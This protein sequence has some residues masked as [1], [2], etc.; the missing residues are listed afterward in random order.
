MKTLEELRSLYET[1]LLP[2]LGEYEA[3]RKKIC[4]ALSGVG[5]GA[6]ALVL[7]GFLA[8]PARGGSPLLLIVAIILAVGA[9]ILTYVL[10]ARGF[11]D[12]FKHDV[13]GRIVKFC[14]PTLVYSPKR[15]ITEPQFKQSR[16][17]ERRID[18]YK[19]EDH[20]AGTIG[21]T[22]IEF[23]EVHAEYKTTTRSSKGHTQTHW[24][25]IF[26]GLFFIGDFNKDFRTLTVVLPDVAERLFGF[27][28][29]KLQSMNILRTGKPVRLEDPEFEK[30]F[31]VYGQDQIEARYVLSTSLMRRILDFKRKTGSQIYLSFVGSH[32]HLG[33]STN[34]NMFEPRLFRTLIDFDLVQSY[35]E[36]LQLAV[37]IVEDLNLNTRIWTKE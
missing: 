3:R 22:H 8:G 1:D 12:G 28:G 36:D 31:A 10:M 37:G 25:T 19:G 6:A 14:D 20:V 33:I 29:A 21:K 9:L 35:L 18:R 4:R 11:V 27:L 7:I 30:E 5:L 16:I 32:V 15:G 2:V 23:S 26:R 24:H 17:F 13:I 34:R